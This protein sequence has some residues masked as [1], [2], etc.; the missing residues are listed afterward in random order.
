MIKNLIALTIL[1]LVARIGLADDML[2]KTYM[3]ESDQ[4]IQVQGITC[5]LDQF[6]E[7]QCQQLINTKLDQKV[8]DRTQ[9]VIDLILA[10]SYEYKSNPNCHWN[11][12]AYYFEDFQ[13]NLAPY[14]DLIEYEKIIKDRFQEVSQEEAKLGD[15]VVYYE[16]N[17]REKMLIDTDSG[18][19]MMKFVDLPGE[20]ITH[21]A[22]YLGEN[23]VFQKENLDSSVFSVSTLNH[24]NDVYQWAANQKPAMHRKR[25]IN[26][27]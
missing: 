5:C 26:H 19:P 21:S 22:I 7:G 12:M 17:I 14:V 9:K 16:H 6:S 3:C 23:T 15:L 4:V 2:T 20:M 18:R 24:V 10:E 13:M 27:V 25:S 11:A 8:L 1:F